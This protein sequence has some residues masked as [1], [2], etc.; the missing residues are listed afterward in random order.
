MDIL[1]SVSG[2]PLATLESHIEWLQLGGEPVPVLDL[3]GLLRTKQGR[4][5]KDQAEA[6]VLR[7][8][9]ERLGL[10]P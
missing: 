8:A 6:Q 2:I 3:E 1:P 4:R 9:L 5:P 10:K 7:A